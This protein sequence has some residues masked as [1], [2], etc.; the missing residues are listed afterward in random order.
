MRPDSSEESAL[1]SDERRADGAPKPVMRSEVTGNAAAFRKER[2]A[3]NHIPFRSLLAIPINILKRFGDLGA[4][5]EFGTLEGEQ[6][7]S[8]LCFVCFANRHRENDLTFFEDGSDLGIDPFIVEK[9]EPG[10][11]GVRNLLVRIRERLLQSTERVLIGFSDVGI[12]P[13]VLHPEGADRRPK[14]TK[15][16]GALRVEKLHLFLDRNFASLGEFADLFGL[17]PDS[18]GGCQGRGEPLLGI[19]TGERHQLILR[20][21]AGEKDGGGL[22]D[23]SIVMSR[24]NRDGFREWS[25]GLVEEFE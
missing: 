10:G 24:E 23:K 6:R 2:L 4:C 25:P 21:V 19:P 1:H 7:F 16:D 5:R 15:V 18:K 3:S 17:F 14:V 8:Q 12:P 11:G 22:S 13:P 9:K 20:G